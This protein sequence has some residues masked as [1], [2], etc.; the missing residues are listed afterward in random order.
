MIFVDSSGLYACVDRRD[1]EHARATKTWAALINSGELLLTHNYL[2]L[3]A[4]TLIQSRLGLAAA[5]LFHLEI[6]PVLQIQWVDERIH[7]TA[8][9]MA[10]AAERRKLSVVDC[11]SFLIMRELGITRAFTFDRHFAEQ[12]FELVPSPSTPS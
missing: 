5:R 7:R 4:G 12:D 11:V 9:A 3:E 10:L 6:A 2:L 1:I 8:V